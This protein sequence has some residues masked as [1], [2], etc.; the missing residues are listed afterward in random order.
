E[1]G[2]LAWEALG[3][4]TRRQRVALYLREV[5]GQS[6]HQIAAALETSDSAVETLLFRAR[7]ALAGRHAQLGAS[8]ADRCLQASTAMAALMD[9]EAS[10]IEKQ[11]LAAHV[12]GCR[13]CNDDMKRLQAG[14]KL[15]AG[16]PLL[17]APK[18]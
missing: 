16:L 11:A 2:R 7:H 13:S 18:V 1:D 8:P 4:L 17:E 9:G 12:S 6:Y 3:S 5:E 15:Y 14:R 10:L